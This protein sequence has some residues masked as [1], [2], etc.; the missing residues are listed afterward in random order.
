MD[1]SGSGPTEKEVGVS[2][3]NA[4]NAVIGRINRDPEGT[5]SISGCRICLSVWR[6]KGRQQPCVLG[7]T[8]T[9]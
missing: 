7:E 4:V 9:E 6:S 8:E 2:L 1:R 3:D 5:V